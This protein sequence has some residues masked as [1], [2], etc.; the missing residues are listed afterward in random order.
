M[1]K[2][3]SIRKIQEILPIEGADAICSYRVDGWWVV[4]SINKYTVGELVIYFEIDSFI[5]NSVCSFLT[6]NAQIPKQFNGVSGERLRSI[7]LR[8]TLSQGLLIPLSKITVINGMIEEGLDVT[9]FLGIQLWEPKISA[10]MAGIAKG[11]FPT[12]LIPKTDQ[13]RV[14]NLGRE[15]KD[16]AYET[17]Q[18]TLK[19]DGTS[20]TIF[21]HE[22]VLRVCSR[23]MEL[24][25]NDENKENIYVKTA[26]IVGEHLPDGYGIQGEIMGPGI[27]NN[28]ENFKEHKFFVYNIFDIARQK[29]Q[30][31]FVTNM[32]CE[33]AKLDHVPILNT[34][35]TLT[36][37]VVANELE[38]VNNL[39]SIHHP[40]AE[41]VVYKSNETNFS[42]K[43]ISNKYLLREK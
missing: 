42:F 36:N 27:Q 12:H 43:I 23:N 10:D 14:Q 19:L 7:K 38:V 16:H 33:E 31:P 22:G 39:P 15:L 34:F 28:R 41:G 35:A 32:F 4:D 17:F 5:P 11:N 3:A 29:Y 6:K 37:F 9:E 25:I 8:N 18:V 21:R 30:S 1:R 26:L 2:L 40:I 20:C 24:L 13:E